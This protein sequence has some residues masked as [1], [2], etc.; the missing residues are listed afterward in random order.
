MKHEIKNIIETTKAIKKNSKAGKY[1]TFYTNGLL[2]LIF[3]VGLGIPVLFALF[4]GQ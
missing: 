1:D 2:A 3:I 4:K